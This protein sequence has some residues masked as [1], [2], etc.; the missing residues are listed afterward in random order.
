M[1]TIFLTFLKIGFLGFGGG[2]AMLSLIFQE[3]EKL[4]MTVQQFADLNALDGLIPGPIAINSAT[5][6]GQL[7]GGF[8]TAVAATLAVCVPSFI[9]VP[10]FLHYEDKINDNWVLTAILDGIKP[11]SVGLILAVA[12]SLMLLTVFGI[13]GLGE[14]AKAS[15]D[16]T[17][18][19]VLGVVFFLDSKYHVNPVWLIL[20]AGL[21]GGVV[22]YL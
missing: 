12:L 7:Y 10:L 5:Y 4:G 15:L 19:L 14:W 8:W 2:Y 6:L 1:I 21:L 9:F 20:L 3:S 18:L 16:W 13:N 22:Y 17:S 11:A